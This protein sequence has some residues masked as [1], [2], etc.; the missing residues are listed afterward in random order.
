MSTTARTPGGVFAHPASHKGYQGYK[1][2]HYTCPE[3]NYRGR[4]PRQPAPPP[5][6]PAGK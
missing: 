3:L 4:Q 2:E 1:P 6:Q 5:P